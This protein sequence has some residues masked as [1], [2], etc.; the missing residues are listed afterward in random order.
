MSSP[1]I[2]SP[3]ALFGV[4]RERVVRRDV[5]HRVAGVREP[6]RVVA[7]EIRVLEA[8]RRLVHVVGLETCVLQQALHVRR[9]LGLL[10]VVVVVEHDEHLR[11]RHAAHPAHCLLREAAGVGVAE[12]RIV[13]HRHERRDCAPVGL[14]RQAT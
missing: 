9:V 8:V 3:T 4:L 5:V 12:A 2:T 1:W 13:V 6:H 11:T 7:S 14:D 10:V